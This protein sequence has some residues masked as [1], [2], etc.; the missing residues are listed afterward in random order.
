MIPN[1][2]DV[3]SDD[4]G[5]LGAG[6]AGPGAV[7][8]GVSG[9]LGLAR[10]LTVVA[11][12]VA[13]LAAFAIGEHTAGLIPPDTV[14]FNFFG[15]TR[16]IASRDTPRVVM[17]TA[18]LAFGVLGLCLGGCLGIAGG[19]ARRSAAAAVAGGSLGAVLGAVLGGGATLALLP[20][21]L[22]MRRNHQNL[23]M[24]IG[25][26]MHGVLWGPLGAAAGLAVAIGQGKHR[27]IGRA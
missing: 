17:R 10:I 12:I 27:L 1:G 15:A 20:S 14:Q 8:E 23:D 24:I 26:L 18:A 2:P 7:R 21:F 9:G 25:M 13:G 4:R 11:G 6:P 3:V 22:E 19:V 5:R 16:G